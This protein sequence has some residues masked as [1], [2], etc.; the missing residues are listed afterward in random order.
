MECPQ[1][2]QMPLFKCTVQLEVFFLI[3][4]PSQWVIKL[5]GRIK[6]IYPSVFPPF[7]G[8]TAMKTQEFFSGALS[9]IAEGWLESYVLYLAWPEWKG[10]KFYSSLWFHPFGWKHWGMQGDHRV[11]II[12]LQVMFE[13]DCRGQKSAHWD[14]WEIEPPPPPPELF[15][16]KLVIHTTK[17]DFCFFLHKMGFKMVWK[18]WDLK[19]LMRTGFQMGQIMWD[20]ISVWDMA[21]MILTNLV[22]THYTCIFAELGWPIFILVKQE[23]IGYSYVSIG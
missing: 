15:C 3:S 8:N 2:S 21:Y 17:C 1:N 22:F 18:F 20:F 13:W 6:K 7:G 9:G 12:K 14:G 23:L 4:L 19:N 5:S 10:L 16:K 11:N